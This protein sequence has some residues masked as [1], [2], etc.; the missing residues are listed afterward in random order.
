MIRKHDYFKLGTF[1]ILGSCMLIAVII[2]LG[3]GKYF[4]TTYMMETYFNESVNGL[5]VGSPVKL[6]GVDVGRVTAINFVLN[7]YEEAQK[8]DNRYVYVE[9]AITPEVFAGISEESFV[10][11]IDREVERGLRVRPTSLGLTG[12]LFLNII[13]VDTATNAPDR[14]SVV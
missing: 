4:E 14:K 5:A 1:I 3:A 10:T 8:N 7:E 2:I 13:Y 12:Q 6:R 11:K 9:C